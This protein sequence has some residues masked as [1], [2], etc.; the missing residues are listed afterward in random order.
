MVISGSMHHVLRLSSDKGDK[1]DSDEEGAGGHRFRSKWRM[2]LNI[3]KLEHGTGSK[4]GEEEQVPLPP[5]SPFAPAPH[6]SLS[7]RIVCRLVLF[8]TIA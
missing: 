6:Q 1:S 4:R 8:V 7:A 2:V 5:E 3:K